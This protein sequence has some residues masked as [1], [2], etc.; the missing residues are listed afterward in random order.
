MNKADAETWW[1]HCALDVCETFCSPRTLPWVV[2]PAVVITDVQPL[3]PSQS[4]IAAYIS[5]WSP[6][7]NIVVSSYACGNVH[8]SFFEIA[9]NGWSTV[10]NSIWPWLTAHV[11]CLLMSIPCFTIPV[12][13]WA[14]DELTVISWWTHSMRS[15]FV[16]TVRSW[17][18]HMNSKFYHTRLTAWD[19]YLISLWDHGEITWT[20][21]FITLDSWY[22]I[23]IWSQCEIRESSSKL[24]VLSHLIHS[25]KLLTDLTVIS[26]WDRMNSQF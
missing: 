20:H 9:Y 2:T 22:E 3:P 15:L 12:C 24:I 6:E 13:M 23:I 14:H 8:Y 7:Y 19:Q 11:V 1:A 25:M 21:S 18:A 10:M 26:W 5:M 16:L 17:W 4:P